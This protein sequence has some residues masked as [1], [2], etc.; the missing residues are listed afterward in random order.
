MTRYSR[1]T[2][3][4]EIGERGQEQISKGKVAII[5]LGGLGSVM[6]EG[7]ARAG[8]GMLRV[9]DRDVVELSN[10]QRQA[11]YHEGNVGMAKADVV[12]EK[13]QK[14]NSEVEVDAR[15][16][17]VSPNNVEGLIED[18]DIVLDA[19]D[20]MKTRFLLNDACVK[21]KV[22]WIFTAILGTYGMTMNIEPGEGPCLRCLLS[23]MP[24]PGSM[25]TC[26]TA[27]VLFS[28]PR[29]LA[30]IAS[31]E[32]VKYLV[33]AD[34]RPTLLTMDI[35]KNDYEQIDVA[36]RD[37]CHCCGEGEYEYLDG[38]EDVTTE[39][40]GRDAVQV[41]PGERVDIDLDK[42]EERYGAERVGRS[43]VK[44]SVDGYELTLFKDGRLIVEGTEDHKKALSVYSE[45]VGR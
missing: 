15:V 33:D 13:L 14:I 29:V 38:D 41:S 42:Y 6:S 5:G 40:C 45:Y 20:N 1:Q 18:V 43:L 11:L 30:N 36:R 22:P 28:L 37:G 7:L 4:P 8:V 34:L 25:E 32:A 17:E 10:L 19:T 27:G 26:A 12:K 9:I 35:W 23:V 16:V 24:D 44:F 31:T 3:L 21:N 2:V 39:L